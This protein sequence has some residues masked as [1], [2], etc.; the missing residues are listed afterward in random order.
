MYLKNKN[1]YFRSI[2]VCRR[3]TGPF[4]LLKNHLVLATTNTFVA[5]FEHCWQTAER[6]TFSF[7]V[8]QS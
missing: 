8:V 2:S 7:P 1:K 4:L 5:F 3:I 6:S